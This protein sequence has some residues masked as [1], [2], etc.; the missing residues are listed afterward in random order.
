V[1]DKRRE[2]HALE[3]R[4]VTRLPTGEHPDRTEHAD[5]QP[6]V[7]SR[8]PGSLPESTWSPITQNHDATGLVRIGARNDA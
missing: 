3:R 1:R 8:H 4:K 5:A 7:D 2:Q 6:E